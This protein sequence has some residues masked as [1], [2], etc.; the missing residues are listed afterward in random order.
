MQALSKE[1]RDVFE[2]ACDAMRALHK[3]C[4]EGDEDAASRKSFQEVRKK[5]RWEKVF[6]PLSSPIRHRALTPT[7]RLERGMPAR[8]QIDR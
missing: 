2:A 7:H 3:G 6:V 1:D 8:M 4:E 5:M